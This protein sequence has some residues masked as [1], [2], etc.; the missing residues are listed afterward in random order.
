MKPLIHTKHIQLYEHFKKKNISYLYHRD[1]YFQVGNTVFLDHTILLVFFFKTK[2]YVILW[3]TSNSYAS[4]A[5]VS[6]PNDA[7]GY[8]GEGKH[9]EYIYSPNCLQIL[10]NK[11]L[12]IFF[13]CQNLNPMKRQIV[14]SKIQQYPFG[15]P[16]ALSLSRT[17]SFFCVCTAA[18]YF[19]LVSF[20]VFSTHSSTLCCKLLPDYIPN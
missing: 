18:T 12:K 3:T 10:L 5:S 6:P 2:K 4:W 17:L 15:R 19:L 8:L 11:I 1:I 9:N 7:N 14:F 20:S 16:P 13:E